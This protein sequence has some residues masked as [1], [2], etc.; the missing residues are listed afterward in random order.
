MQGHS[1]LS[2]NDRTES[3]QRWVNNGGEVTIT[4][5]PV[6]EEPLSWR[7]QSFGCQGTASQIK[8]QTLILNA[9]LY[10]GQVQPQDLARM[11]TLLQ[12]DASEFGE[13]ECHVNWQLVQSEDWGQSW[14]DHW[15]S[16]DIGDRLLIHPDWLPTPTTDRL[17]LRLN[18]GVAF[19]TGAH[20]TTQLCLEALER[21]LVPEQRIGKEM[22]IADIGCGSGILSIAA[23]L[24][25]ADRAYAV[26]TDPLAVDAARD[27][28]NLNGLAPQQLRIELGSIDDLVSLLDRPVDGFLCNILA[29]V[30]LQLIPDFSRL[31]Q[32]VG[33]GVLSGI[34]CS[35][36]PMVT[37]ALEVNGWQ[38][39]ST[40][41]QA[42]WCCLHIQQD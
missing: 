20:A 34:L 7:L 23:L 2:S 21:Q 17:L 1:G 11:S 4:G 12:Q 39:I 9:Y 15:Q 32:P 25:G 18:P 31:T 30:I 40:H 29:E 14:K 24:L 41:T 38:V 3:K 22:V 27:S 35:Q 42:D 19:G 10:Q 8:G 6:L 33:W 5:N 36:I 26:D 28:R 13:G 37:S 16:Q